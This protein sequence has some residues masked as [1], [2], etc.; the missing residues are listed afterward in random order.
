[1]AYALTHGTP[2]HDSQAGLTRWMVPASILLHAGVG[3]LII[4]QFVMVPTLE[5]PPEPIQVE[6]TPLVV[7]P[8]P[9][10]PEVKQDEL[11]PET[12]PRTPLTIPDAPKIEPLPLPPQPPSTAEPT[13]RTAPETVPAAAP[14]PTKRVAVKYPA[15]AEAREVSG[16][17]TVQITVAAGGS[18]SAVQIVDETPR[19]Y[20]FGDA[21]VDS[22]SRWEFANAQPGTYRVTVK[23]ELE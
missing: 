23:F 21:A 8:P 5:A 3:W 15:R 2:D 13:I 16:V 9:P 18:V 19:G 22:V 6:I 14:R 11:V 1:M 17:A 10:P 12:K 7:P 4:S 20:G